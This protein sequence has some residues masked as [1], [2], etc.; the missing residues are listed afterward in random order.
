[1]KNVSFN[2]KLEDKYIRFNLFL[3]TKVFKRLYKPALYLIGAQLI[4]APVFLHYNRAL[5]KYALGVNSKADLLP[6]SR[7]FKSKLN[8]LSRYF[9]DI[10]ISTFNSVPLENIY[11]EI[12]LKNASL[13]NCPNISKYDAAIKYSNMVKSEIKPAALP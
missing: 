8:D 6:N 5:V 3:S 2:R 12:D 9:K 7:H 13:I 1:M 11:L 10:Y 4:A